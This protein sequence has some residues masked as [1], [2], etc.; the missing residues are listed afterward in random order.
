MTVTS[1]VAQVLGC[2]AMFFLADVL[3]AV[4]AKLL[5]SRFHKENNFKKMAAALT[6]VRTP[7]RQWRLITCFHESRLG[8]HACWWFHRCHLKPFSML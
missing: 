2:V 7:H 3:K 4:F 8:R 6:N 1:L 5:S